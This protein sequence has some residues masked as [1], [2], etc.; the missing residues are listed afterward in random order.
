MQKI[1]RL[2]FGLAIVF[3]VSTSSTVKNAAANSSVFSKM[4]CKI[5]GQKVL[6][7]QNGRPMEYT[8]FEGGVVCR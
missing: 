4:Q 5:T 7:S 6:G 1:S 2:I 8:G 3:F